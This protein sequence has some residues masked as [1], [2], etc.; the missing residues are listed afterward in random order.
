MNK[1]KGKPRSK[2]IA[3]ARA[4]KYLNEA[5]EILANV[6]VKYGRYTDRGKVGDAAITA[7]VAAIN[8]VEGYLL[9]KGIPFEELP[10]SIDEYYSAIKKILKSEKLMAYFSTVDENLRYLAHYEGGLNVDM[11]KAGIKSVE[12]I[13]KMLE[14]E[15]GKRKKARNTSHER[16]GNCRSEEIS[17]K[18]K[19]DFGKG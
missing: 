1:E 10:T 11:I 8:A 9:S 12:K 4:K 19:R 3:L 6:K 14:V 16:G 7:F 15:H 18:C 17:E 5:K 2:G 13:I